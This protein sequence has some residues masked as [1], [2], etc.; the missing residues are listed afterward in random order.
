M[1]AMTKL[2]GYQAYQRNKYETAS[3]HKLILLLY[4]GVLANIHHARNALDHK[5]Q[6][7]V[8]HNHMLKAQDILYE[9]IS[10][11]NES[12]GGEIARNLKQIYL[13]CIQQLTQANLQKDPKQLDE[14]EGLVQQ[15]RSA[16][17]EIGK[18]V[19]L[20]ARI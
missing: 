3:P 7:A 12:Q 4:D 8:S 19:G 9:L 5:E 16:W 15:L 14:V 6:H 13:Y 20:G 1:V 17:V 18:D 11:L 2:S 10:C